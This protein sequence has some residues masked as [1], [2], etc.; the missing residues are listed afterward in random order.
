MQPMLRDTKPHYEILDG[1]RGIAAIVVVVFHIL[2]ILIPDPT[3]NPVAHGFLAVDFFFCL[4]GFVIGYAYDDR[5]AKIGFATFFLNRLIRLHPLVILGSVLGL[6]AFLWAP[7]ETTSPVDTFGWT[8]ILLALIGSLFLFPSPILGR[9]GN[10]F[11]LNAPAWSLSMEYFIN[12]VYAFV[13]V[14]LS[15]KLLLLFLAVSTAA[16][17]SVASYRGNILGGWG[18]TT[19]ADGY[20]R[21][22]F[23]FLMGLTIF[24]FQFTIKNNIH[25]LFYAA[26]LT[27]IFI[28][29]HFHN[30]WITELFFVIIIF[31]LLLA[32][33]AGSQVSGFFHKACIF[34]GDLSYPLYMLHYWMMWILIAYMNT[35]PG[36]KN[37]HLAGAIIVVASIALAYAALKLYDEPI[38]KLLKR[39]AN[40]NHPKS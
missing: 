17:I 30:D 6:L 10:V 2:E 28:F 39:K 38:R 19:Y 26:A 3:K 21:V 33:G 22:C 31:P 13:L 1:L 4:S 14:H 20:A 8:K 27:G 16:I 23:S 32:S 35:A 40:H 29:P 25:F 11:P 12:L 24:R 34:L 7:F 9:F 36:E 18:D 37:L 5:I 15:K